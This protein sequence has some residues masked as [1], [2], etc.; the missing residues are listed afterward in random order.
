MDNFLST[1]VTLPLGYVA[2]PLKDRDSLMKSNE[3]LIR[4]CTVL[5]Q[6]IRMLR[7]M[8][9]AE[10]NKHTTAGSYYG[11]LYCDDIAKVFGFELKKGDKD[12][13]TE[14]SE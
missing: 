5:E 12:G 8:C 4:E 13:D 14:D 11:S 10:A 1:M 3:L 9:I 7:E 6:K 2:I